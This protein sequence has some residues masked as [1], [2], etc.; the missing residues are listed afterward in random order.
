MLNVELNKDHEYS[1]EG[2]RKPGVSEIIKHFGFSNYSNIPEHIRESALSFGSAVHEVIRQVEANEIGDFNDNHRKIQKHWED[3]KQSINLKNCIV[4]IKTNASGKPTIGNML[5]LYA[6]KLLVE[7]AGI[8]KGYSATEQVLYS[9]LWGFCGKPD[10][11]HYLGK[12]ENLHIVFI[13]LDGFKVVTFKGS[14]NKNEVYFKSMLQ[15]YHLQKR[16]GLL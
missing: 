8:I 7:T 11:F 4:D 15:I 10:Y 5:Q 9:E 13:S 12:I 6:Y 16:E 3:F 14:D 2:Q 1:V